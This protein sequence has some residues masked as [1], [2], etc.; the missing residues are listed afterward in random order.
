MEVSNVKARADTTGPFTADQIREGDHY[1]LTRGHSVFSAPSSG[2]G[3]RG[4]GFGFEVLDADPSA[5]SAG[6]DAGFS[7]EGRM[8][9]APDVAVGNVPDAHGWI[10]GVPLLALEYA[11]T[12]QDEEELQVKIADLLEHGT[13]YVWV[14]RLVGPRRVE[15]YEPGAPI[16]IVLPG[17]SL[18]APGILKNPV[19]IEALYDRTAAHEATLR[20]LL[21]RKG[22]DSLDGVRAEG[23]AQGRAQ[24]LAEGRADGLRQAIR[25][26]CRLLNI[27]STDERQLLLDS[28]DVEGLEALHGR[29]LS[30]RSW[31]E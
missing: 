5:E 3:A 23:H 20:N 16:R 14:V 21:Q 22:Y 2:S 19:P 31:R 7:P 1:E 28:L 29:I 10:Q 27:P 6:V 18:E 24:G 4:A 9:R 8:L 13:R 12:H 15:V 11:G 25:Q 26:T 30:T 17:Q